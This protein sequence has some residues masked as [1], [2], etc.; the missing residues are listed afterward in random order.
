MRRS[1]I[2][3]AA[4]AL[5]L[6]GGLGGCGLPDE[7]GVHV[8]GAGPAPGDRPDLGPR[9]EPPGRLDSGD[10][11]KEFAVNFLKAPAGEISG[12][13]ERVKAYLAPGSRHLIESE[14]EPG[15]NV[16]RLIAPIS[17]NHQQNG[18]SAVTIKV[19]QVGVLRADGTV[20]RPELTDTS[21]TFVVGKL[22][23]SA[24]ERSDDVLDAVT[25]DKAAQS[26][27]YVLQP[28]SPALLMSED[29]LQD[30][31]Q[32]RA[33]YFWNKDRTS[34]VPDLRH[35]PLAVPR[36]RRAD[37]VVGWLTR[38]PADWLADTVVALPAGTQK[39]GNVTQADGRLVVNLSV[40]PGLNQTLAL[41]QLTTQLAW[42]LGHDYAGRLEVKIKDETQT[43][44]DIAQ[45]RR[46]KP[47][48]RVE[49]DLRRFAVY[50][51]RVYA[52]KNGDEPG[53]VPLAESVNQHIVSAAFARLDS[54]TNAV[55][56]VT[57]AGGGR[58]RL[59][60]GSAAGA[61]DELRTS[62]SYG[63]MSRPVWL[64]ST[65]L[66][67]PRGLIVADGR[68][69]EFGLRDAADLRPVELPGGAQNVIAVAVALDG[70][71][72]AYVA[73]GALYVAGLAVTEQAIKVHPGRRLPTRLGD[74]TAVDWVR[75]NHLVVAG[76]AD[77]NQVALHDIGEDGTLDLPRASQR[78]TAKITHLVAYAANP[79]R[80]G[81]ERVMYEVN[82]VAWD[83]YLYTYERIDADDL[84]A[85]LDGDGTPTAP[86][87][88][89]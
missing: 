70:H 44:V 68:L 24:A 65:F 17:V 25:R 59:A 86:F 80:G 75:E 12:A 15:I 29:A 60:V 14:D 66:A 33:I 27:L 58:R 54:G 20:R 74:L 49:E 31:Y 5:M 45:R 28:P 57:D 73:D 62:G 18:S 56:L 16:V 71:R 47:V 85:P 76:V 38:G 63:E 89:Y 26:G 77:D 88:V 1:L 43:I 84:G 48:Y 19:Q 8:E 61:V 13:Y 87:F 46:D 10:N 40:G 41:D 23:G 51:G 55:A 83:A 42:S 6:V 50:D 79:V 39:S 11:V 2:A 30:Y 32:M 7:T 52:L 9:G 3:A 34:L 72:I 53:E 21:Y 67:Q 36:S 69:Y 35:L 78:G 4:A 22:P 64:R 81:T 37:E 82:G